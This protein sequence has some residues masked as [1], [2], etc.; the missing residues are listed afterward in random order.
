[1]NQSV[2]VKSIYI[3]LPIMHTM[4]RLSFLLAVIYAFQYSS[5]ARLKRDRKRTN[6][7]ICVVK[8]ADETLQYGVSFKIPMERG[9]GRISC[10]VHTFMGKKLKTIV[11]GERVWNDDNDESKC[12][13]WAGANKLFSFQTASW[14]HPN[15][16][17]DCN[18]KSC[19]Q[20]Y[21]NVMA[22]ANRKDHA[23]FTPP[24]YLDSFNHWQAGCENDQP[25]GMG[26]ISVPTLVDIVRSLKS[27]SKAKE[28]EAI[29]RMVD[30]KQAL[31]DVEEVMVP[32]DDLP[33]LKLQEAEGEDDI[34]WDFDGAV[35]MPEE[36]P[37][38]VM[39]IIKDYLHCHAVPSME[40]VKTECCTDRVLRTQ[41]LDAQ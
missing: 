8:E 40:F 5:G 30:F 4:G 35:E 10:S 18:T 39:W 2:V 34:A 15:S 7:G 37:D 31:P 29:M 27:T 32:E 3:C 17:N 22:V 41:S 14:N 12:N 26:A 38:R 13:C 23:K 21:T 6:G 20:M 25:M 33:L 11:R 19:W 9:C 16:P 28:E 24:D 1:L 36:C